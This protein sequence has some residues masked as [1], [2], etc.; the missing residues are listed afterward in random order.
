M[1]LA[2][3]IKNDTHD[4]RASSAPRSESNPTAGISANKLAP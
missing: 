2:L 3:C 1:T 4:Q